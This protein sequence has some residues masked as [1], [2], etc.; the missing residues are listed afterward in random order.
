MQLERPAPVVPEI[1]AHYDLAEVL[2]V[3]RTHPT[4]TVLKGT[5]DVV[6]MVFF[7]AESNS[8]TKKIVLSQNL[9]ATATFGGKK[10]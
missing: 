10:K 5:G 4:W 3:G 1:V 2:K 8:I 6:V 7:D 9:K